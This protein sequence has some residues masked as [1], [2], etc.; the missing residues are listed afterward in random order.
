MVTAAVTAVGALLFLLYNSWLLTRVKKRHQKETATLQRDL[1]MTER[2][3]SS[4][5]EKRRSWFERLK[6]QA[7]EPGRDP[8]SVV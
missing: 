5:G 1:E 7:E 6:R 3:H 2:Q 4:E 8:E